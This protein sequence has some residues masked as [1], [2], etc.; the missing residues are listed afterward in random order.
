[1]EAQVSRLFSRYDATWYHRFSQSWHIA[2]IPHAT[3]ENTLTLSHW[4]GTTI[5]WR[6]EIRF[7][8]AWDRPAYEAGTR[9]NQ[10]T[11][12]SDLIVHF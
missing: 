4:I 12:A 10:L 3:S 7:D 2:A 1:L 9:Q 11:L 5:Q 6:L 8:H